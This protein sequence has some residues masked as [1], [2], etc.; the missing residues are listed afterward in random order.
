MFNELN[1]FL[2]LLEQDY[3][4]TVEFFVAPFLVQPWDVRDKNGTT[5]ETLRLDLVVEESERFKNADFL[6]YNTGHWWTHEKTSK[7]YVNCSSYYH[8]LIVIHD[9]I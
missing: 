3:N 7:G 6:I 5:K 4:V 8:H 2:V 9:H 1:G